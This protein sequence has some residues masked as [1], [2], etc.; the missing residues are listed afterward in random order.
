MVCDELK[1]M[2][3]RQ[4]QSL[5]G[6][7][8]GGLV[9]VFWDL[10][11]SCAGPKNGFCLYCWAVSLGASP[12]LTKPSQDWHVT[13]NTNVFMCNRYITNLFSDLP[14]CFRNPAHYQG[15]GETNSCYLV[16]QR[17]RIKQLD[18]FKGCFIQVLESLLS[19]LC[20]PG[21]LSTTDHQEKCLSP[22]EGVSYQ[23]WIPTA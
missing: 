22:L 17:C 19:G 7:Q 21:D 16:E 13:Q 15:S 3:R 1:E 6:R 2:H 10:A 8:H 23:Q 14:T 9:L 4:G 11:L 5:P 20:F 12:M 18:T